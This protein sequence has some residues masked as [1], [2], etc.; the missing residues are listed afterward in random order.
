MALMQVKVMFFVC[1]GYCCFY[2][3]FEVGGPALASHPDCCY[4]AVV[5][6]VEFFSRM[7]I[8]IFKCFWTVLQGWRAR[9]GGLF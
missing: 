9:V 8:I 3:S 5:L 7:I 6:C 4:N 1:R 2:E